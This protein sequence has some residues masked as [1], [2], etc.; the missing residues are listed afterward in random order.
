MRVHACGNKVYLWSVCGRCGRDIL[1]KSIFLDNPAMPGASGLDFVEV[2]RLPD[3]FEI[4]RGQERVL[5]GCEHYFF[6]L[7]LPRASPYGA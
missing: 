3:E 1:C 7:R 2:I 6:A 5:A 4:G